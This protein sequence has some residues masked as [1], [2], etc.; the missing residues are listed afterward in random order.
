MEKK[1]REALDEKALRGAVVKLYALSKTPAKA[2]LFQVLTAA[3]MGE[4]LGARRDDFDLEAGAWNI[5]DRVGVPNWLLYIGR[6]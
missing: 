4:V 2:L 5:R 3:R 1:E 6:R